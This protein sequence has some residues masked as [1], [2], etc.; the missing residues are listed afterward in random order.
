M[1]I[2]GIR[3]YEVEL[4]LK[5]GTYASA[6][7][8]LDKLVTTLIALDTDEGLTGWGEVCPWGA[9]YLPALQ[10]AVVPIL[11]QMAPALIGRDPRMLEEIN[12]AMDQAVMGQHFVKTALDYACWDILGKSTALPVYVLLG[13]KL[14]EKLPLIASIPGGVEKLH[15]TIEYYRE[16]G[17]RQYS[18]HISSPSREDIPV[19]RDVIA[20]FDPGHWVSIDANQS[21]TMMTAVEMAH[22]FADQTIA[23]EQPLPDI[24][25]CTMLRRKIDLPIILD[26]SIVTIEDCIH[27]G[28]NGAFEGIGLKI[29]R[30]GGLTRARRICDAADALGLI[31]WAKDTIG[32]EIATLA[33]A[34]LAHARSPRNMKGA[35]SCMGLVDTRTGDAALVEKNGEMYLH[36]M[37]PGLGFEPDMSVLGSPV[38]QLTAK[39]I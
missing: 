34:H 28:A 31:Y 35:L 38:V 18:L 4:G 12:T 7:G 36:D 17:F 3:A 25:Q 13:G 16:Q 10:P 29:G 33:T 11:K 21:W 24:A 22:A 9:A 8:S 20:G 23:L 32:S 14:T 39:D 6:K 2:T 19:Y 1:K 15:Q 26:E 37:V 27:A 30:C 5:L